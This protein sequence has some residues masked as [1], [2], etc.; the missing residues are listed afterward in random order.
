MR[1]DPSFLTINQITNAAITGVGNDRL[2]FFVGGVFMGLDEALQLAGFI[3]RTG[4]GLYGGDYCGGIINHSMRLIAQPALLTPVAYPGRLR[5]RRTA[6]LA[7]CFWV[8]SPFWAATPYT[9]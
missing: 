5:S 3:H 2:N 1:S 9:L 4:S 6:K 7:V 8:F